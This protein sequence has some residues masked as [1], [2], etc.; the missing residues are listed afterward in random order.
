[1][2][3]LR[4]AADND[5]YIE[6]LT[7]MRQFDDHPVKPAELDAFG[8]SGLA[9]CQYGHKEQQRRSEYD[10]LTD[11]ICGRSRHHTSIRH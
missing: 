11:E 2:P 7:A 5:F 4:A 10:G 6:R 1:L 3:D 8:R 9:A